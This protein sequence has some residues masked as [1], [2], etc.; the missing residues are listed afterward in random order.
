MC[1]CYSTTSK[2][3]MRHHRNLWVFC[4][5]HATTPASRFPAGPGRGCRQ[6]RPEA[7]PL[8][9][10]RRSQPGRRRDSTRGHVVRVAVC[11]RAGVY[12]GARD[13]SSGNITPPLP[14]C[15]PPPSPHSHSRSF[16]APVPRRRPSARRAALSLRTV[17][18]R[19]VCAPSTMHSSLCM[20]DATRLSSRGVLHCDHDPGHLRSRG[21]DT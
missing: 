13:E 6:A 18:S 3:M 21:D 9:S 2:L 4:P 14:S 11:L 7:G 15:S 12:K 8:Q 17:R 19:P 1:E 16:P 10:P 5:E 20:T